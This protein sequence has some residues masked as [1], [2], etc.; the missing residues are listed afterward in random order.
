M[1]VKLGI[2]PVR[3]FFVQALWVAFFAYVEGGVDE[4][5]DEVFVFHEFAHAV[6]VGAIGAYKAG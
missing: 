3:A 5:F 6:A 4:Y 2:S 1:P